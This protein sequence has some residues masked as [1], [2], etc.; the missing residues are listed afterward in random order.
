MA[1]GGFNTDIFTNAIIFIFSDEKI[2]SNN[3]ETIINICLK[4][5]KVTQKDEK[6][7]NSISEFLNNIL[8]IV[9]K[10]ILAASPE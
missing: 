4:L 8:P 1:V 7:L 10:W 2:V 5:I 9:N 6:Y 3:K